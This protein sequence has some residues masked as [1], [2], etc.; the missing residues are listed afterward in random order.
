M[1]IYFSIRALKMSL[2]SSS[3][4]PVSLKSIAWKTSC[5]YTK[6]E[7]IRFEVSST[8][9]ILSL[10]EASSSY[11]VSIWR[12]IALKSSSSITP[13]PVVSIPANSLYISAIAAI[14]SASMIELSS[15]VTATY[16]LPIFSTAPFTVSL[17]VTLE[18][19]SSPSA[20][21]IAV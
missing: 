8:A 15:A 11:I 14:S 12:C 17:S 7:N 6:E 18:K 10:R 13:S 16:S 4:I 2:S 5:G 20:V 3:G 9:S 19:W 21:I 1:S